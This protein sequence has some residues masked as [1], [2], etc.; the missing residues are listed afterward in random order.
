[1]PAKV[2][3]AGIPYFLVGLIQI[4]FEIPTGLTPGPQPVVVT[5]GGVA[6]PPVMLDVIQ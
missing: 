2:D 4:N 5:V 1:V 6:S 3:F